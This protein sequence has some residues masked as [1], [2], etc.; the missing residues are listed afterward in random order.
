MALCGIACNAQPVSLQYAP[1]SSHLPTL[2]LS[3]CSLLPPLP[4][5]APAAMP[6]TCHCQGLPRDVAQGLA[7][8]TVLGSAKMVLETGR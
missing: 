8:Q 7:A 4:H 5:A 6:A 3:P 1:R 2:L